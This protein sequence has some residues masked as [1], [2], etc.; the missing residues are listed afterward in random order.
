MSDNSLW[1]QIAGSWKQFRGEAQKQWGKLT[2][3][4]M[5]EIRGER[6]KLV[7]KIQQQYG[8]MQEEAERQVDEWASRLR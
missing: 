6:T 1:N 3:D 2:D 7:G 8:I 4:D 5:E